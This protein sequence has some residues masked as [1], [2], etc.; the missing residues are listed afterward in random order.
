MKLLEFADAHTL[1]EALSML[2]AAGHKD[3]RWYA[4]LPLEQGDGTEPHLAPHALSIAGACSGFVF[5]LGAW[6]MQYVSA[7][8]DYPI[9]VGARPSDSAI[10]FVPA[11]WALAV[12]GAAL[13]IIA[14]FLCVARL[15]RFHQ[16]LFD[17]PDFARVSVDR[18][19]LAVD[20][21]VDT[22]DTNALAV[23]TVPHA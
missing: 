18:Y 17:T 2:R 3:L 10:A 14:A 6:L 19:F 13:G 11:A 22:R 21:S 23:H 5:G 4:P 20:D 15:P 9:D 7:V 1:Q 8:L 16:P 12:L